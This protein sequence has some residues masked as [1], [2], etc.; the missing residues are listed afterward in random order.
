MTTRV[1]SMSIQKSV[2]KKASVTIRTFIRDD[3]ANSRLHNMY[4]AWAYRDLKI[5]SEAV[6]A[7]RDQNRVSASCMAGALHAAMQTEVVR[8]AAH[9]EAAALL[10]AGLEPPKVE[11]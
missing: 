9:F 6:Q 10:F 5:A 8:S 3:R 1:K 11:E 2:P 7:L 4:V